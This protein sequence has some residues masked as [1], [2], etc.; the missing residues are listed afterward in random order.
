MSGAMAAYACA[1]AGMKVMLLEA[2]RIGSGGSGRATGLFSG[3]AADSYRDL[4]ARAGRRTARALFAAMQP[5]PRELAATVKRLGIRADLSVGSAYRLLP[6]AP[7]D[8]FIK[9]EMAARQDADLISSL[10]P[11]TVVAK[12]TALDTAGAMKLPD[13]G[14]VDPLKLTLGFLNAAIKKGVKVY[15]KSAVTKITFTR[16]TA[17][18]FLDAGAITTTNLVI[19]IGEPT[20]LFKPLKRHLRHEDRY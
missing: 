7:A 4:E 3:E 5:A 15:E 9:R 19:C 8:K 14:F 1:S 10:V 16:K 13:A 20:A 6:P 17:T 18:A 12:Q 11:A 2:D